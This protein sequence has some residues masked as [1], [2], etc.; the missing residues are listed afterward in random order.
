M[1]FSPIRPGGTF[2]DMRT[3]PTHPALRAPHFIEGI[4][5]SLGLPASG[6]AEGDQGW[7]SLYQEGWHVS[8]GV[9]RRR[10]ERAP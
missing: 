6:G 2:C 9:Y 1:H 5:D 8:A 3:S 4:S 7:I 10:W